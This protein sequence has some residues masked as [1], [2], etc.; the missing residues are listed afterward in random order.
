MNKNDTQTTVYSHR[1]LWQWLL[2][3]AVVGGAIYA[4]IYLFLYNKP[5]NGYKSSSTSA[6]SQ[7]TT[8]APMNAP[9]QQQTTMPANNGYHW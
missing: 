3:Y 5:A 9:A 8:N 1:P 7:T 6:T 2:I 4:L